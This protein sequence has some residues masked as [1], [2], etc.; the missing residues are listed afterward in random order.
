[1][2]RPSSKLPPNFLLY[3]GSRFC[4]AGAM[5]M[6]RAAI[7]WQVFDL[8]H[9]AFQLGLIGLVQ[10]IPALSLTLVGGAVADT[11]DRRKVMMLAQIV[12]L[13]CS[14]VLV[15]APRHGFATLPLIYMLIL[16]VATAAAFDSPSRAAL[17][18]TLV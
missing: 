5:T 12:P 3:L 10:F 1:M 8:S 11:Y 16:F 18:P 4:S 14:I 13:V 6:F 15:V 9:S 7:A 2:L 17:L